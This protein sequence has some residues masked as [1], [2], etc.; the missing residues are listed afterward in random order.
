MKRIICMLLSTVFFLSV[1]GCQNDTKDTDL[2]FYYP[3]NDLGY[4]AQENRFFGSAVEAEL[5]SDIS[6]Q[7]GGQIL[8]EYFKGPHDQALVNPFPAGL[9]LVNLDIRGVILHLTVSDH[10]SQLQD[11]PLTIACACLSKTAML[12]TGATIVYISCESALLNGEKYLRMD[13]QSLI[14]DDPVIFEPTE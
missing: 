14:F 6:Y 3:K 9:T 4:N 11:I 7:S 2:Q 10:L 1:L 13:A 5:R 12:V 8:E